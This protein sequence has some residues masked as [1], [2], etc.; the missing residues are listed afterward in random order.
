MAVRDFKYW[1][2]QLHLINDKIDGL[3]GQKK[4]ILRILVDRNVEI[5][6][7]SDYLDPAISPSADRDF[8]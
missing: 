4:A 6:D 7:D 3:E 8:T 5:V 2:K 1:I